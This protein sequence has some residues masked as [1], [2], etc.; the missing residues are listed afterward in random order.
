[1]LKN[2]MNDVEYVPSPYLQANLRDLYQIFLKDQ[3]YESSSFMFLKVA[4]Q[5]GILKSWR[6]E[7][8]LAIYLAKGFAFKKIPEQQHL[9]LKIILQSLFD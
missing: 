7:L 6:M 1:M 2:I 3:I 8:S 4:H 5:R 9:D